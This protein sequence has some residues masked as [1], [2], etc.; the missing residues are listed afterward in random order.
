MKKHKKRILRKERGI[1]LIALV[2]TI[3]VLLILASVSIAMLTGDNGILTQAQNAKNKTEEAARKEEESLAQLE[4]IIEGKDV[5]IVQVNDEN[6]GELEQEGSD[7]F[8]INSIEDLVFFSH[9][10]TNENDYN[11][12]TVK[13]G[14]NLDF[15]SDK[16]Y[17]APNSTDYAEYGYNGPL[18]Q[19]LTSGTGFIPIGSQDGTN[20]FY[21]TFDG[22]DKAICSLYINTKS[23]DTNT[24]NVGLFSK[25]YGEIKNLGLVDINIEVEGSGAARV[26]GLLAQSCNNIYD[27]YVTGSIKVTGSSYMPV[28]GIC[29]GVYNSSIIENCYNLAKIDS[30]NIKE[31]TGAANITCAGIV[32]GILADNVEINQCFNKGNITADGLNNQI[33]IGGICGTTNGNNSNN[34]II[35]NCYNAAK[36]EGKS[37]TKYK[38]GIGGIIGWLNSA[39]L[40]NCYN[41]GEVIGVGSENESDA[42]NIG[43]IIGMLGMIGDNVIVNNI[44]NVGKITNKKSVESLIVG[45][46]VGSA[47][48][49]AT[50]IS[51]NKAYNIGTISIENKDSINIGSII[52]AK[53]LATLTD[54]FYLKGTYDV[55]AGGNGTV[56]EIKELEDISDFPS[57]LEVVN[58]EGA[59]EEDSSNVNGG[60]PVLKMD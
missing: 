13:L 47:N 25:S 44:Y 58:G 14:T 59:F 45:G 50:N 33:F 60:Y 39:T 51:I 3:I 46:I 9:D 11:G 4:A 17:V 19:A 8:V 35:T 24:K 23:D 26:G 1:T 54:C 7:T 38:L 12:K 56:T 36:I 22:N 37:I 21:G 40:S 29:A 28:G 6:P 49:D 57:V 30:K 34:T 55:G 42:F 15:N 27:C 16:S 31:E 10:V 18:K 48:E 52:G 41:S 43:G 32:G 2:I 53:N 20:S 5:P